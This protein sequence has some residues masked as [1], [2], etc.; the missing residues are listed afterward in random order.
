MALGAS[1]FREEEEGRQLICGHPFD[2][3]TDHVLSPRSFDPCKF[4]VETVNR[5]SALTV[6]THAVEER[7]SMYPFEAGEPVYYLAVHVQGALELSLHLRI[8]I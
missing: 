8:S 1:T 4:L 2:P 5:V 7:N 3:G 6:N